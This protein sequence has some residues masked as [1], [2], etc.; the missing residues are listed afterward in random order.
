M[1]KFNLAD[2]LGR[3]VMRMLRSGILLLLTLITLGCA[4]QRYTVVDPPSRPLTDFTA[5]EI[6]DFTSN[7][8]DIDAI[9]KAYIDYFEKIEAK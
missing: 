3:D 8:S 9:V 2:H 7:L 1:E 6:R 4:S 5:L